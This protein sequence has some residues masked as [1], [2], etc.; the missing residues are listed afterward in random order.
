[1]KI[2]TRKITYDEIKNDPDTQVTAELCSIFAN[3]VY[4]KSSSEK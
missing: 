3:V 4:F 1:M 2:I